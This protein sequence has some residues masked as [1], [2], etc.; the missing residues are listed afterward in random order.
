MVSLTKGKIVGYQRTRPIYE[1]IFE[2]KTYHIAITTGN[3]GFIIG[4]NPTTWP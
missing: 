4:A 3:N 1:V 2:G